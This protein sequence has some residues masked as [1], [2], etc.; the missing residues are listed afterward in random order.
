[1]VEFRHPIKGRKKSKAGEGE[2][3]EKAVVAGNPTFCAPTT[4]DELGR[5]FTLK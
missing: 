3:Q 4:G 5:G 2:I 1:M